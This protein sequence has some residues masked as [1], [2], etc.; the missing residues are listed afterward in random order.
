[1]TIPLRRL[2]PAVLLVCVA[3]GLQQ[4]DRGF[5][6]ARHA[7]VFPTCAGC[8]AGIVS[9]DSARF[10][11]SV[12][13]CRG[14]HD[15]RDQKEVRWDGPYVA[16]TNL[17]FD[18]AGHHDRTVGTA[19]SLECLSCHTTAGKA[20][21]WMNVARAEPATCIACHTH[22]ASEHLASNV[23]CATCH[24]PLTDA[25]GLTERQVA[26]F[27][28]PASHRSPDFVLSHAP[29]S[30]GAQAQCATCHSRES[31][32]RCHFN[33]AAVPAIVS[34]ARDARVAR[35]MAG[36]AAAYPRPPSHATSSWPYDH[37]TAARTNI[38]QC[39]NCHTRPSCTTCHAGREAP[40]VIAQLPVVTGAGPAG[41]G[42]MYVARVHPAGFVTS[43]GPVA[44]TR[45][46][47]CEGCHQQQV[48]CVSCHA[49]RTAR[50]F[51]PANFMARH[52]ADSYAR[53]IDCAKCHNTESFCRTCHMNVGIASRA[54]LNI[55]FHT[56]EPLWLLQ[57][58]QA[59]RRDL[60]TCTSCHQ[61]RDCVTCHSDIG[62][63]VN[64]HGPNFNARA[65][66]ERNRSIC[67]VC[68]ITDPFGGGR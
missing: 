33:A 13:S 26:A 63:H 6:H 31:C 27:D 55:A 24:V 47:N 49:G 7:K 43:H 57:H 15:G 37:G 1:M 39:A 9:G 53:Q 46:M 66:W 67:L 45:Q 21:V 50:V 60:A 52:A 48:F 2:M 16:A 11:P 22:A 58:G 23:A 59:A 64:P 40:A 14:C 44:A 61:E 28:K 65:M 54:N 56:A 8:H 68:H 19:D 3:W 35:L 4:D 18:H 42:V 12:A 32:E 10:Y 34:L 62:G 20:V 29:A 41:V 25:T 51:H 38:A 36:R 17:H 5:P 30:A